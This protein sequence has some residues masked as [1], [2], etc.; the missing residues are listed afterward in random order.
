MTLTLDPTVLRQSEMFAKLS[1]ADLRAVAEAGVVRRLAAGRTAFVQGDPGVSCHSLLEG[2]VKVVKTRPDGGQSVLRFI[3]PGEMYG[4]VAALM[5][6]PFPADA[7]A[8]VDSVELVWS[9]AAMRA[10][11]QRFPAIAIGSTAAAGDRLMELQTRVGELTAD[12]VERRI[13]R[14]LFRLAQQAG[15]RTT[16]GIEIDFPITRQDLAEMSGSTLHTVSRTLSGWDQAG[17]TG[18]TRRHIVL[19]RPA[20]LLAIAEDGEG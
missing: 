2:R 6:Q 10:L 5:D 8:V 19:R 9:V 16:D 15:R 13:A 18:S 14:A 12:R 17:I 3:G 7:V 11:M 1:D 4:T 20:K